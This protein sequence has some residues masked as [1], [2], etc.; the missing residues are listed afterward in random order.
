M[1]GG[2]A[3][4][5]EREELMLWLEL[6]IMSRC[7]WFKLSRCITSSV[8]VLHCVGYRSLVGSGVHSWGWDLGRASA[9]HGGEGRVFSPFK[10]DVDGKFVREAV[11]N[12]QFYCPR[13]VYYGA[14]PRGRQLGLQGRR[15]LFGACL[16]WVE[17]ATVPCYLFCLG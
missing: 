11:P 17:G 5:K 6:P 14:R 8:K 16:F 9:Y 10:S 3:G 7:D 13:H 1:P 2:C 12:T 4:L 15:H